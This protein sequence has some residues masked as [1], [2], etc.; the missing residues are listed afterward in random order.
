MVIQDRPLPKSLQ[1]AA[2]QEK[3]LPTKGGLQ[4][5]HQS[6]RSKVKSIKNTA[7]RVP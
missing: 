6:K 3:S 1:P 7:T 4:Q 2:L 5:I